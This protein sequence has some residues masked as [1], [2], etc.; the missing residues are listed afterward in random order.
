MR[1]TGWEPPRWAPTTDAFQ[2][3]KLREAGAHEVALVLEHQHALAADGLD[4]DK[5]LS[6]RARHVV[7]W[8]H[9]ARLGPDE[10][11]GLLA[12]PGVIAQRDH[13]GPSAANAL[14]RILGNPE[15]GAR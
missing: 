15:P 1:T 13:V 10:A 7:K 9:Q 11:Q 12:I 14:I 8:P 3:Q 2:I 4:T 6:W 5:A